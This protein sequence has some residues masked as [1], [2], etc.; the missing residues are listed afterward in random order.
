MIVQAVDTSH[1]FNNTFVLLTP[2]GGWNAD[3]N[4]CLN[5]FNN[6]YSWGQLIGGIGNRSAC[7]NLPSF[8]QA[9]CHWRFDWFMDADNPTV[10]Y[11]EVPCPSNLTSTTGCV[12]N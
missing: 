9:G 3:P 12:R 7:A 6:S 10:S 8:L 11:K 1:P 2:G 5:Q 4:G